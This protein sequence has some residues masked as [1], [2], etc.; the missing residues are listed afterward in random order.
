MGSYMIIG[1]NLYNNFSFKSCNNLKI[2]SKMSIIF[3]N[4]NPMK[5]VIILKKILKHTFLHKLSLIN[6]GILSLKSGQYKKAIKR[7]KNLLKKYPFNLKAR[8]YLAISYIAI[9]KKSLAVKN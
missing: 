5:G 7:F 2:Q 9:N 1:N 3:S 4:Q 6:I 8:I